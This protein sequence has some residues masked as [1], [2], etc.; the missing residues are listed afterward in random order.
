MSKFDK[1]CVYHLHGLM[2]KMLRITT[3]RFLRS[4]SQQCSEV[5]F[6]S[7]ADCSDRLSSAK[8]LCV[9]WFQWLLQCYL[10][11][12]LHCLIQGYE[13]KFINFI[14][15]S[16][17]ALCPSSARMRVT[18]LY[19]LFWNLRPSADF[20]ESMASDDCWNQIEK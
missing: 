17:L 4:A 20:I 5:T 6:I 18:L 3:K 16:R 11:I 10:R 2:V 15:N 13:K 14:V 19:L 9:S 1:T 8:L 7:P 12:K